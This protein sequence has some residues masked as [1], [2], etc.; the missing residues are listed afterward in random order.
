MTD[1]QLWLMFEE[2]KRVIESLEEEIEE[3]KSAYMALERYC[4]DLEQGKCSE[5]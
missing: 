5:Q 2:Q 3:L 1:Y 4:E